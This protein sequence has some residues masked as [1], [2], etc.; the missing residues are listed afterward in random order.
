MV[1]L[2]ISSSIDIL[3]PKNEII[4]SELTNYIKNVG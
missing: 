2:D 4:E 1:F 3:K